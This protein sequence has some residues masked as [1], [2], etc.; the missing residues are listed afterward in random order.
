M[1]KLFVLL[2]FSGVNT[3]LLAQQ[4]TATQRLL[5][6]MKNIQAFSRLYPQEKVYLHFD[7][8][9]YYLG[10]TMWFQ[11]YVVTAAD[12]VPTGQ[13]KVLYV[14]L[15]SAE[16]EILETKKLKIE[17]GRANGQ[18]ELR[19]NY[20]A[21]FYE[22]RAYTRCMLNF[23]NAGTFSRVFPVYNKPKKAGA[24]ADKRMTLRD[25]RQ[26]TIVAREDEPKYSS[27]NL[28]FFPEGGNLVK[29]L[30]NRVAFKATNHRGQSVALEGMVY[31]ASEEVVATFSTVHN[32]MGF[33][34]LSVEGG[35][36]TAK[37]VYDK[38]E[39]SFAL[40][41][42]LQA[43]YSL[44]VDNMHPQALRVYLSKSADTP[45]NAVGVSLMLGGS[46][47]WFEECRLGNENQA[48]YTIPKQSLSGGIA[49]ITVFS[50]S[51]EVYAERLAFVPAPNHVQ[52]K[53]SVHSS[54]APLSPVNIEFRLAD[55]ND[56][57][58]PATFSLAVYD[59]ET[60]VPTD[61]GANVMTNLL[62]SSDI[63]GYVENPLYYFQ[64]AD[65]SKRLALDL[66]LMVQGWRRYE[67]KAMASGKPLA[68]RHWIEK[69]MLVDGAVLTDVRQKPMQNVEVTMWMFA[70]D[71]LSQRGT[72]VTDEAGRFNFL[73]DDFYG[74]ANLNLMS[75]SRGKRV[76]STITLNRD[77]SIAPRAYSANETTLSKA[78]QQLPDVAVD[79]DKPNDK[80]KPFSP[81]SLDN[82]H[83]LA[84]VNVTG[85]NKWANDGAQ[86]ATIS[87]DVKKEVDK[88]KDKGGR[89]YGSFLDFMASMSYITCAEETL[90]T[91]TVQDQQTFGSTSRTVCTYKG[92][93][94]KF[95]INGTRN[96]EDAFQPTVDEATED[97]SEAT[98]QAYPINELLADD[99]ERVMIDEEGR[100]CYRCKPN[101]VV[102]YVYTNL[103]GKRRVENKG[104]R[105]TTL[106]GFSKPAE[107]YSP[108]YR[109]FSLPGDKDFRRT[110]YWNPNVTAD[111][112]GRA[113]VSFDNNSSC[114]KVG[115]SA[116]TVTSNGMLG[117]YGE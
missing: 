64:N 94:V 43:G 67:W 10:E 18:F 1:R 97:W 3:M 13:S 95:V 63:K 59:A 107:F 16:G 39:Y 60:A 12:N 114:T 90:D 11:S 49:Q 68:V 74:T 34:D 111:S 38:K 108:S 22:V 37:V 72:C 2:L 42:P 7:N 102:V 91:E 77:L 96:N 101:T 62:L 88:V 19:E 75:K 116:E 35:G 84:E 57:P 86:Y 117:W 104:I 89:E 53:P 33:F 106:E 56:S 55:M 69:G 66:L 71:G 81:D 4:D 6:F 65:R 45:D 28:S 48:V 61:Y 32:G 112:L 26:S 54:L 44:R 31:N 113:G 79:S 93:P 92:R 51:G 25:R 105:M 85:K 78:L 21:G 41:Q 87:Y 30:S 103:D 83:Q 115:I 15:L 76:W 24:Y 110:L 70:P 58:Q 40:P 73:L 47:Y 17:Q 5:A 8:T 80:S 109:E 27:L 82:A 23:D 29:G 52:I 36:Y 98:S 9:G 14:E 50:Q 100:S 20:Y 99:V 46:L